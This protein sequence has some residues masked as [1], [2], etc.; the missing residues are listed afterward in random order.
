MDGGAVVGSKVWE[1]RTFSRGMVARWDCTGKC[2]IPRLTKAEPLSY[3]KDEW[4]SEIDTMVASSKVF[5][6]RGILSGITCCFHL[7]RTK[8]FPG[9]QDFWWLN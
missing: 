9:S 6:K 3:S 1:G 4:C 7:L 5:G 8:E 2:A